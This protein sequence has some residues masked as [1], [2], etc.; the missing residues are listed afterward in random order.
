MR[1]K[2]YDVYARCPSS[3]SY[4]FDEKYQ[5][6]SQ[7]NYDRMIADLDRGRIDLVF[8]AKLSMHWSGLTEGG[9]RV[10]VGPDFFDYMEGCSIAVRKREPKLLN[11]L[12]AALTAIHADDTNK[13]IMTRYFPF[14]IYGSE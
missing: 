4:A 13:T 12:N 8:D 3:G 14:N 7:A 9:A 11:A 10:F 5:K 2:A 1:V 6:D